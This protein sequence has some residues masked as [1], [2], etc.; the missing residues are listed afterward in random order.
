MSNI[1]CKYTGSRPLYSP[2]RKL[3][4]TIYTQAPIATLFHQSPPYANDGSKS[5]LS[6]Y[7]DLGLSNNYNQKSF[8]VPT[9]LPLFKQW[10]NTKSVPHYANNYLWNNFPSATDNLH[11]SEIHAI[12]QAYLS[13]GNFGKAREQTAIVMT[14]KVAQKSYGT[15]KR[16]LC[17]PSTILLISNQWWTSEHSISDLEK[18][19]DSH[20]TSSLTRKSPPIPPQI[21][22][23]ISGEPFVH[24]G[25]IEWYDHLGVILGK[26][27]CGSDIIFH[28]QKSEEGEV[29]RR[30]SRKVEPMQIDKRWYQ[31][32]NVL[33]VRGRCVSKQLFISDSN[34]HGG[35]VECLFKVKLG[36]NIPIGILPSLPIKVISKPSKKKK[37][38]RNA[39]LCIYHGD[40]VSLFN[41]VRSQTISTKYLSVSLNSGLF[42]SDPSDPNTIR[43]TRAP[44][45]TRFVARTDSWDTFIIWIVD[46]EHP[47]IDDTVR[48]AKD[49]IGPSMTHHTL[50]YP[51][52]P[53]I[54]YCN[55]TKEPLGVHY[56]QPIVLQCLRTGVVSPIMT[57]R[58][59]DKSSAVLCEE[60]FENLPAGGERKSKVYGDPVSQLHRIAVQFVQ[61]FVQK[62]EDRINYNFNQSNYHPFPKDTYETPK[63]TPLFIPQSEDPSYLAFIDETTSMRQSSKLRKQNRILEYLY[64]SPCNSSSI[65]RPTPCASKST[66]NSKSNSINGTHYNDHFDENTTSPIHISH[67]ETATVLQSS[68]S[69][70]IAGPWKSNGPETPE[71]NQELDVYWS[72][73]LS[74]TSIWTIVGTGKSHSLSLNI[75]SFSDKAH[76][77]FL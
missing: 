61:N 30:K 75:Y 67:N 66:L 25:Y 37:S 36:D 27:D 31:R 71:I 14:C 33:P 5:I 54:A 2:T 58:K 56:N 40:I 38:R 29:L 21:I 51:P 59:V 68:H 4:D 53:S 22:V 72:K 3:L 7:L 18:T 35:K 64:Y 45:K 26:T 62:N 24:A 11:L 65:K 76:T 15:E 13:P 16:F 41:R 63:E 17:P 60:G 1:T 73:V 42:N 39:E 44:D 77:Y 50:S 49:C 20:D 46:I 74:D 19:S 28:R 23:S 32:N 69:S 55:T 6:N 48:E 8:S 43:Y 52:P 70:C 34:T 9:P 47:L 57:I 10:P 12:L